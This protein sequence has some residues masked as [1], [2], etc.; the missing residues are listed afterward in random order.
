[1]PKQLIPLTSPFAQARPVAE[2]RR[3]L[4]PLRGTGSL[5]RVVPLVVVFL[6]VLADGITSFLSAQ[7]NRQ[8]FVGDRVRIRAP[9]W[10]E[11]RLVGQV[12][13]IT[14][15]YLIVQ[16]DGAD[17]LVHLPFRTILTLDQ[18]QGNSPS[19]NAWLRAR[20]GAFL[21]GAIGAVG[22]PVLSEVV[23][24]DMGA[25]AVLF[26]GIGAVSGGVIGGIYGYRHPKELWKLYTR[27]FGFDPRLRR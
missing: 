2:H 9:Y 18:Y 27:P 11:Q 8:H 19:R 1:M 16:P 10:L 25:S 26:A 4:E 15:E 24:Y 13:G 14:H 17:S 3:L 21:L 6:L 22:G 5:L 20:Q 23:P 12:T 7:E